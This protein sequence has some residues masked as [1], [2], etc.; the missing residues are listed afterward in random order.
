MS[1]LSG[2]S[3]VKYFTLPFNEV[4]IENWAKSQK[5]ALAGPVT[6]GQLFTTTG[7]SRRAREIME[8]VQIYAHVPTMIGCSA[9]GLI[10][11][12]QEIENEAGC[13]IALSP[14][15][16]PSARDSSATGNL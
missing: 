1:V 15:R 7:C 9:S 5:E 4:E 6:F 2:H 14:T 11:G 13:C 10:A 8:I 12:N 3:V 16:H